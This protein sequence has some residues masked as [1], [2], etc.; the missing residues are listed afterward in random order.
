MGDRSIR[1]IRYSVD[2]RN[3][4]LALVRDDGLNFNLQNL[5]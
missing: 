3:F 5:E 4:A 2:V 1:R